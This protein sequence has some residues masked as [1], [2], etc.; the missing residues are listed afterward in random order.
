M[1]EPFPTNVIMKLLFVDFIQRHLLVS[2]SRIS[3]EYPIGNVVFDETKNVSFANANTI[4]VDTNI[5]ATNNYVSIIVQK[6][7]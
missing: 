1:P 2:L 3:E 7:R 6:V 4:I 5:S